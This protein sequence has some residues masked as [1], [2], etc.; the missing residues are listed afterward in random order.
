MNLVEDAIT[1]LILLRTKYGVGHLLQTMVIYSS[2][3]RGIV[4]NKLV[5]CYALIE[6]CFS[7]YIGDKVEAVVPFMGESVT[8]GTLANFL[9]SMLSPS[10]PLPLPFSL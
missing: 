8:D 5:P 4:F 1:C 6:S 7:F 10:L 9:K 2:L 3:L